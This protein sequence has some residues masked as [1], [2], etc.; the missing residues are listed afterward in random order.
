MGHKFSK[1]DKANLI[2]NGNPEESLTSIDPVTGEKIPSFASLYRYTNE[3]IAI[4]RQVSLCP[5][6]IRAEQTDNGRDSPVKTGQATLRKKSYAATESTRTGLSSITPTVAIWNLFPAAS[7]GGI[8][9]T[10]SK[11]NRR[12]LNLPHKKQK[13]RHR[14]SSK[15]C[16]LKAKKSGSRKRTHG[17]WRTDVSS[18]STTGRNTLSPRNRQGS[19]PPAAWP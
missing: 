2:E 12:S 16:C 1:I 18:H 8:K 5:R 4:P 13:R 9:S 19:M 10:A 7:N 11:R 17:F 15:N 14:R 3:L 6:Y